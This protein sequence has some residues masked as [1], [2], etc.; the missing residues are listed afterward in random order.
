MSDR[1]GSA[2]IVDTG[3]A[4]VEL[5][6]DGLVV[7]TIRDGARQSIPD[8]QANLAAALSVLFGRRRPL[9][10]DIRKA[11]PLDAAVRHQYCGPALAESFLA[12]A[13]LVEGSPLGRIMGNVYLRVAHAG[14]PTQLFDDERRAVEWL[15]THRG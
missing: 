8:A 10:V 7:V 5:N 14:I 1:A 4:C 9:L 2:S 13:L 3:T 11:Q 15:I 6:S 12:L